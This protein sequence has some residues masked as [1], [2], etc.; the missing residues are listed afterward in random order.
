MFHFDKATIEVHGTKR[1]R[2][3]VNSSSDCVRCPA[4]L[5]NA[6]FSRQTPYGV[7]RFKQF[8][9]LDNNTIT[10]SHLG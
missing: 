9:V 1:N 4:R 10:Q 8:G 7:E 5:R 3:A 2:H 6:F